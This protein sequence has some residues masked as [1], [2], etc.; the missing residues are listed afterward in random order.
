MFSSTIAA[1]VAESDPLK[2]G[3]LHAMLA[4]SSKPFVNT[5]AAGSL[6]DVF[7][8][9]EEEE[10]DVV[11]TRLSLPD[12]KGLA[13]LVRLRKARED[14]PIVVLLD[15]D[16]KHVVLEAAQSLADECL[17]IENLDTASFA[18]SIV[19]AIERRGMLRDLRAR[20]LA[21]ASGKGAYLSLLDQMDEAIFMLA[22]A[23][24]ALL[25]ANETA[26]AWFG[27]EIGLAAR[28]T[29][30]LGALDSSGIE[31]ET[32]TRSPQA[33]HAELRSVALDWRGQPCCMITLRSIAKRKRAEEAYLSSQR[34]LE[35]ALRVS[36]IGLWSWDLRNQAVSF[37]E[38]WKLQLGYEDLEFPDTLAGFREALHPDDAARVFEVL[39][40]Y[41]RSPW[42]EFECSYRIR[43]KSGAFRDM[44]CRGKVFPD[45]QGKLATILGT[46]IDLSERLP[47]AISSEAAKP[48]PDGDEAWRARVGDLTLALQAAAGDLAPHFRGDSVV[49]GR[50]NEIG[51]LSRAL[52][53]FEAASGEEE[54]GGSDLAT[55]VED[56]LPG[57][58]KLRLESRGADRAWA[59]LGRP[60]RIALAEAALSIRAGLDLDMRARVDAVAAVE[61]RD[62]AAEFRLSLR[63]EG[64]RA[65][66]RLAERLA[67]RVGARVSIAPEIE[68]AS[69]WRL[70]FAAPLPKHAGDA[71]EACEPL[72]ALLVEDEEVLRFAMES[73]MR[74]IGVETIAARD[75][76]EALELFRQRSSEISLALID[77]RMPKIDGETVMRAIR[78]VAPGLPIILM[79][80]D[81][82]DSAL[83]D[84]SDAREPS[85]FLAKPFG[86]EQL[87]RAISALRSGA[88]C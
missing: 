53:F 62:G 7:R 69:V 48:E 80:G 3:R 19:M 13:A 6:A 57:A 15:D 5:V 50:I 37:S 78:A 82:E 87:K 14:L 86:A 33:P 16:E 66:L 68:D 71:S 45:A 44:L 4:R 28:E 84:S 11:V 58:A 65:D 9:L 72:V 43:H 20:Q 42:P 29:V 47:R 67:E 31:I 55:F 27:D 63:Y 17:F 25:F 85:L 18:Q 74:S 24:G 75:G 77:L 21:A 52:A 10:C 39:N 22:R 2:A 8:L 40:A 61:V 41:L 23:D 32:T 35:M 81:D 30:E 51:R 26:R 88:L 1:L 49:A 70:A 54:T 73:L 79:S 59:A 38:R 56:L 76:E 83:A 60:V 34:R 12:A 36:N 46:Q 64:R